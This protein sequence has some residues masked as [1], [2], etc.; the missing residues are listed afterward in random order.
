[1]AIRNIRTDGDEVLR[2]NSKEVQVINEKT[3]MLLKDMADTLYKAEGV[4]LAAPQIGLLK[5]LVVIDVGDGLIEL[6]NPVI[7]KQSGEQQEV[8]GC[9]SIPEVFGEVK[10][11]A[12]VTV[13]ALNTKGEVVTIEGKELL[14]R[15]LCHEIDHLDG[16]LF[17]DKV[18]RFIDKDDI[19]K[20]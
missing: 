2:K 3:I 10:R 7:I 14:A 4:G 16:I 20:D 6:I 11:P 12:E 9:L 18:I 1:M 15:A 13:K 17:K 19:E 5:R 8:E